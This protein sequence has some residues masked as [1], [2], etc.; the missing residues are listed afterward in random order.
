M[1]LKKV[2]A[3]QQIK[4]FNADTVGVEEAFNLWM[5][6]QKDT[7]IA[8]IKIAGTGSDMILTVLYTKTTEWIDHTIDDDLYKII[9]GH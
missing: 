5:R 3:F 1:A 7:V 2:K 8:D 9:E 6:N 4:I